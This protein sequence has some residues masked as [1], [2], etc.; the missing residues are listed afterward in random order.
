MGQHRLI[1]SRS[2]SLTVFCIHS[3]NECSMQTK[4]YYFEHNTYNGDN[5]SDISLSQTNQLA[6]TFFHHLL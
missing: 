6:T 5:L 3:P 2:M 4:L 1:H